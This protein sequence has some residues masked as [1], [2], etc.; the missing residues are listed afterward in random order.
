MP[1]N[2][3]ICWVTLDSLVR[4]I[5][6][7]KMLNVCHTCT[8]NQPL[9]LPPSTL[10]CFIIRYIYLSCVVVEYNWSHINNNYRTSMPLGVY[11]WVR[12]STSAHEHIWQWLIQRGEKLGQYR[13]HQGIIPA[14]II[15]I[16][17]Y[18]YAKLVVNLREREREWVKKE[19]SDTLVYTLPAFAN[20]SPNI[21]I[22]ARKCHPSQ[23]MILLYSDCDSG[24]YDI[25]YSNVVITR[26]KGTYY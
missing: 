6:V 25:I 1:P 7:E 5:L 10:F 3:C 2:L 20:K 4:K 17:I 24:I 14:Y 11:F 26:V 21:E 16:F 18:V 22:L 8:L 13:I 19:L 9:Y 23:Y 12:F 15:C